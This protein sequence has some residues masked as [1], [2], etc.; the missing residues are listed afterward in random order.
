MPPIRPSRV[1]AVLLAAGLVVAAAAAIAAEPKAPVF[2]AASLRAHIERLASDEF[3]GR[4]PATAGEEKTVAYLE[5]AYKA[6]GLVPFDGK[7]YRQAVPFI[8]L[9]TQPAATIEIS[10]GRE[11]L[12]LRYG[13]EAVY[14]TT[15]PVTDQALADSELVFVGYGIVEPQMG[16]NDYAGI[17]MR[18][19][20]AVVLVN[21][22]GFATGDPALFKGRAMTYHGRWTYKFEEASRQG[23]AAVLI[24]HEDAPAAYPWAVVRNGAAKPQLI[25]DRPEDT[26]Y[27]I[28]IEGWVTHPSAQ[29]LFAAAGHDYEALKAQAAQR[30]FKP[31]PLG[32]RAS[33]TVRNLKRSAVSSNVIGVLP[34]S[35]R[36]DEYVLYTAHWDHLGKALAFAGDAVFNGAVDN[37]TGTAVLLELASAFGALQER[38]E[39]SVAFV[40]FTGEEFGLLGSE[41]FAAHSPFPLHRIAGGINIDAPSPKGPTRDVSV[42]GYGASELEDYLRTAADAQQRVLVGESMPEH[43]YYYRS[44]H[45]NLAKRGV[46]MLYFEGGVDLR[47]GGKAAGEAWDRDYLVN[48]YHKPTD[49]YDASWDVSGLLEELQLYYT[50]GRRLANDTRFPQWNP[51]NEFRPIRDESLRAGAATPASRASQAP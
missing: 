49:E 15:R 42:T 43:G 9:A 22:P 28:G 46:P 45:F 47:E 50:V 23:A 27:R 35:K 31:V 44:D 16:W 14:W 51:G 36:P 6:A 2:D 20:T 40:A 39:R 19:K 29:R 10:G 12:A 17:D 33:T 4:R 26:S 7:G 5:A 24:V 8:E 18:G 32:L 11:P 21:D 48:R 25:I 3:E 1:A 38:P 30:G 34:G 37:A 13:E 41:Y